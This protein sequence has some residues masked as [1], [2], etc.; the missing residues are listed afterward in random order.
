MKKIKVGIDV[1]EVLRARWLQFDRYYV[2]EY[3]GPES[4]EF[5]YVYDFFKEYEWKDTTEVTQMFNEDIPEDINPMDYQIDP[6]TGEAPVDYIAFSA[7]SESLTAKEIYN[8]F[9]YMDYNFEIHGSA[10]VMYKQMDLH[11]EKFYSMYKDTVDF[12][13]LSQENW[14]SIPPTLFFL[15]R[16]MSRFKE[17][18]FVEDKQEMWDGVDVLITTDPEILDAGTPDGIFIQST[19]TGPVEIEKHLIK[20]Q[21]PYNKD[22][23]DGSLGEAGREIYHIRDF[24]DF[25]DDNTNEYAIAGK[26][27]FQ[28]I[29]NYNP[30]KEENE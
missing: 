25:D 3:G 24:I 2:E 13:I 15:S 5:P 4:P 23:Q 29:I 6:E 22:C 16:I 18:R 8:R 14:F 17:F 30:K 1:N 28:K 26:E 19:P 7:T 21:R 10:P 11:V 12:V 27:M 9:M 20:L